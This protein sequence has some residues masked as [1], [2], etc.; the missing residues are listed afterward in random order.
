LPGAR[1]KS[2]GWYDSESQVLWVFGGFGLDRNGN[3]GVYHRTKMR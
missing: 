3:R 1:D 2:V